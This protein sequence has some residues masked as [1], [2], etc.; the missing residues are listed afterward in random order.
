MLQLFVRWNK[1]RE[2]HDREDYDTVELM[3]DG[4]KV[5]RSDTFYRNRDILHGYC[6]GAVNTLNRMGQSISM[7]R[8]LENPLRPDLSRED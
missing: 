1:G 7:S 3:L 5:I 8:C 6:L 4:E 2:G